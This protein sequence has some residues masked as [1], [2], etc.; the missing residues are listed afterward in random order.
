MKNFAKIIFQNIAKMFNN[1]YLLAFLLVFA[2]ATF[3]RVY[4]FEENLLFEIDQARDWK[5]AKL[6]VDEGW[7]ELTLLGP[8]AG[9]TGFRL[10]PITDYFHYVS[11]KMFGSDPAKTSYPELFFSLMSIP[12]LLLL[13][14]EYFSKHIALLLTAAYGTSLFVLEYS[15][16][17][18]NPNF[19][20]FFLILLV[21]SLLKISSTDKNKRY[22]AIASTG[23]SIAI[24]LQLHTIMIVIVPLFVIAY[25]IL[26]RTALK[27]KEFFVMIAAIILLMSPIITSEI[28]LGFGNSRAFVAELKE[29][30]GK[31][32]EY[33]WDK[34]I[35]KGTYEF[36]R[37]FYVII[38]SDNIDNSTKKARLKDN[39]LKLIKV[40]TEDK[41]NLSIIL[42]VL[43]AIIIAEIKFI[44]VIRSKDEDVGK[45]RFASAMIILIVIY[46]LLLIFLAK[47]PDTRYYLG[48][49]FY[50]F[51]VVGVCLEFIKKL[52]KKNGTILVFIIAG[53][54]IVLN[55]TQSI[56]WLNMIDGYKDEK[57]ESKMKEFI[58]EP[59]FNVTLQQYEEIAAM[60]KEQFEKDKKPVRIVGSDVYHN[61]SLKY[62]SQYQNNVPTKFAGKYRD[63]NMRY[64]LMDE[65]SDILKK[66]RKLPEDVA[67]DFEIESEKC[68][69]TLTILLLSPKQSTPEKVEPKNVVL[70]DFE[71]YD[72]PEDE[73]DL[74]R[75]NIGDVFKR[76]KR[77]I[78]SN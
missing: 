56:R 32:S 63:R 68:F 53:L 43:A 50:P 25:L 27:L 55:L 28:M 77:K 59:Y 3:L 12:L 44:S 38:F 76:I 20:P 57:S 19:L 75:L 47:K 21:Y 41:I 71:N 36:S 2:V 46:F 5:N 24:L 8:R 29:R 62:I 58:L 14:R 67:N 7:K 18:W 10:G 65:T 15:R 52:F 37:S 74:S 30:N 16:F 31:E 66:G 60:F 49:S 23:I 69:G 34:K 35:V 45:K 42:L 4:N 64:Y 61:R 70:G 17:S 48:L 6:A 51:V 33:G 22:L 1:K 54:V 13:L 26:T 39:S 78:N 9:G 40:I 11:L 73:E 72:I